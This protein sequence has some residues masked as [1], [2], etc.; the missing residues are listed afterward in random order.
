M[1]TPRRRLAIIAA[2]TAAAATSM[3]GSAWGAATACTPARGA[4]CRGADLRAANL[5]GV[6]LRRADLRDARLEGADLRGARL[7]GARMHRAHLRDARLDGADLSSAV[8]DGAD[9]TGAHLRRARLIGAHIGRASRPARGHHQNQSPTVCTQR[10]SGW[11]WSPQFANADLA[12]ANLSGARV[13]SGNFR[14]AD[15][16]GASIAGTWFQQSDLSSAVLAKT[17]ATG[18]VPTASGDAMR[19]GAELAESNVAGASFVGANLSGVDFG[20]TD[21]SGADFTGAYVAVTWWLNGVDDMN[22][23]SWP[24]ASCAYAPIPYGAQEGSGLAITPCTA[25]LPGGGSV[26]FGNG[27][28]TAELQLPTP[29]P[30][31]W[32]RWQASPTTNILLTPG[33]AMRA[34]GIWYPAGFSWAN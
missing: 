16:T 13:F 25:T 33:D 11:C 26:T 34:I 28:L 23:V 14:G 6:D 2:L 29:T 8:L 22:G 21:T 4:V 9:F 30:S 27:G 12:G 1:P 15:L 18:T 19:V 24:A 5:R 31:W 10:T 3:A 32:P 7:A 17:T 20:M